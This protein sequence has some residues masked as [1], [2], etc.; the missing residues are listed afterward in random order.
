M[1]TKQKNE[2]DLQWQHEEEKR[3]REEEIEEKI[4]YQR[5]VKAVER[6]LISSF[7]KKK[8]IEFII[9]LLLSKLL[10]PNSKVLSKEI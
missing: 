7:S 5:M 10:G 6:K 3:K 1:L 2:L 4:K 8:I 9:L